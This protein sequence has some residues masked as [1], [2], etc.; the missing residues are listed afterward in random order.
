MPRSATTNS[1]GIS[2][3]NFNF[4]QEHMPCGLKGPRG[5]PSLAYAGFGFNSF[6]TECFSDWLPLGDGSCLR[7]KFWLLCSS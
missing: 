2:D 7:W 4:P 1:T 3:F 5:F 6:A